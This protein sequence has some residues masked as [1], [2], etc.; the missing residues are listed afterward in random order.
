M[1]IATVYEDRGNQIIELP[2]EY[3]FKTN[4]A[5]VFR[6]GYSLILTPKDQ[7]SDG[8]LGIKG[9]AKEFMSDDIVETH[10]E[11]KAP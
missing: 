5:V 10:V 8:F 2:E 6:L 11:R 9:F 7:L 3:R 1:N 4:E